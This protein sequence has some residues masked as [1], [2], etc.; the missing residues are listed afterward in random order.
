MLTKTCVLVCLA[1]CLL[2]GNLFAQTDAPP[3]KTPLRLPTTLMHGIPTTG[4]YQPAL[5]SFDETILQYMAD[6][7]IPG[8]S[9]AIVRHGQLIYAR[10]YGYADVEAKTPATPLSQFRLASVSKPIT[11]VAVM[12]LVQSGK[13]KLDDR[14]FPLLGLKPFLTGGH[15]VDPRL[16]TITVRELLQHSGGWDRDK[17]GDIMFKHF[18]I[19]REMGIASPPDHESLIRWAMGQPLDFAPGTHFAYSNFGFCVLGRVIEKVS[20]M[21]YE[22]YVQTK[23]LAPMNI[24]NM[25]IGKGRRSERFPEE[26][27]Y[28]DPEN[29]TGRS[30][31]SSDGN[32]PTPLPYAF[33]S[34]ETLDAHGGW[35]ASAVDMA[36]FMAKLDV[37][38][39]T[40]ILAPASVFALYA[41]PEPPLGRDENGGPSPAYYGLGWNVRPVRGGANY[42]HDG[43]M[44]G[45]S[46][47]LVRLANGNSWVILF[48]ARAD[49]DIDGLMHK[50]A[51]K[52]ADWPDQN[53]FVPYDK[54]Q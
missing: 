52:V 38:G 7:H 9:M 32:T 13:L 6:N 21:P 17:S 48:N 28:Y 25:R 41:R 2:S 42:W 1:L 35:I 31:F 44:P 36:R 39:S 34:P 37:P 43:G 53:L 29:R 51:A 8:A 10:G 22:K 12:T 33:A 30:V 23:V 14:V 50:A 3:A 18:Q 40:P 26:V 46:T 11:S 4:T 27:C 49:G 15:K 24:K 19:A 16:E 20:G 5:S 54:A 45:T 47:L